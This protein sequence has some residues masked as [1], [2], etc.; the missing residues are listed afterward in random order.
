MMMMGP[1]WNCN[2]ILAISDML[3]VG[4]SIDIDM[5]QA[6]SSAKFWTAVVYDMNFKTIAHLGSSEIEA[7]P[8]T[9]KLSL[10]PGHYFIVIRYYETTAQSVF[11]EVKVDNI[12]V[13]TALNSEKE[14]SQYEQYLKMLSSY[15]SWL[16]LGMHYHA[17][18][19]LKNRHW[20]RTMI[21]RLRAVVSMTRLITAT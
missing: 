17:Y 1:R 18:A 20:L 8:S 12:S 6:N 11:P 13:L 10:T 2:A 15:R 7:H 14:R 5:V 16:F 4:E 19:F 3:Y 9:G 21:N